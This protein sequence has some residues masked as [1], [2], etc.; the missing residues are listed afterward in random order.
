[1]MDYKNEPRRDILC[2]DAKSFFASVEA[3]EHRQHPLQANIAVVSKPDND[4]GL[5][6]AA[7]PNVKKN[8]GIKT[9]SRVFDIPKNSDIQIVEP[10][11]ALYLQKNL[12]ILKI[13]NRYAAPKD[14]FPYSIDESFIDV[15]HSH[16]LFGSSFNIAN[17]IQKEA[18]E[19]LGLILTV[20]IGSNPL[21]AKLALDHDA[22]ND[23]ESGYIARWDYEDVSETVWPIS[24]L[25]DFW[26][27]GSKTEAKL[28]QLGI[29]SIFDLSQYN[30]KKLKKKLGVIG[31]Q[32]FFHA[33][34][35]DRTILSN[36]YVPKS[37]SFSKNQIL[38]YDYTD[39]YEVEIIIRE[40]TEENAMRLRKHTLVTGRIKLSI[41]YSKDVLK[42]GFNHQML[43]DPTDSSKELVKQMLVIFRRYYESFPVRIVN[44]SFGQLKPKQSLQ[45]NL[46]DSMEDVLEDETLN[47]VV[48]QVRK[49]Y[50]YTSLLYAS[51]LLDGGMAIKRSKLLGGHQADTE[52][53][54]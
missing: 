32:L 30:P 8:Y 3:V 46:F 17:K 37:T 4:G 7:S 48:D 45:L 51:S 27:I 50:G 53:K 41:G 15:S 1:M 14:V 6:L 19:Q 52:D 24:P 42:T 12:E 16:S 39:Q 5:V 47:K 22:K 10:R 33:H 28:N 31:E 13:F 2:I 25:T 11:M 20:G 44:V 40:M 43:I 35:I 38:N 34:G 49:K 29:E 21:L 18:W 9:G 54:N 26:G 36:T 23:K